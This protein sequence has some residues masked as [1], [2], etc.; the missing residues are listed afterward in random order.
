M[1]ENPQ[2]V[3]FGTPD[4]AVASLK[5]LVTEGLNVVA[6]VT[7]VDKPAGRGLKPK[8]S[9]VKEYAETVKIPILQPANLKDSAFLA[10]L[11][12]F[13]PDLQIVIAFRMLPRQVWELPPM[14]T[15]NLHAS[16]LPQY[17]GAAPINRAVMN[18]ETETGITTFFLN[19]HID[20]GK[21][22][23]SRKLQIG[24]EETA[25][26]LHDRLMVAGA[27]LVVETVDLIRT[28]NVSETSQETLFTDLQRLKTAP[29]IFK[30]DCRIDWS[31]DCVSIFNF[32]R[33]LSPHPGA[34]TSFSGTDS[35]NY[36]IKILR[37]APVFCSHNFKP[38]TFFRSE[39]TQL[40]VATPDGWLRILELQLQGRKVMSTGDFMRGYGYLFSEMQTI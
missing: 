10:E 16:L 6:V 35:L 21:I 11:S 36:D 19:E 39:K 25:G 18:G 26:I 20:T 30:E 33:G 8:P 23:L 13:H 5:A 40:I 1:I 27:R 32:I 9:P 37:V 12:S 14:G 4:F 7:A 29:K 22:I 3:F 34:F 31:R 15:F 2:I 24:A 28:G 17:R 38:G